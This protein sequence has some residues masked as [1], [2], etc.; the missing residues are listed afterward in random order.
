MP[1]L[2]TVVAPSI[3]VSGLYLFQTRL[4]PENVFECHK[5]YLSTA[6]YFNAID[7]TG[8]QAAM[9]VSKKL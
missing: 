8:A 7:T 5:P 4:P 1:G 6:H 9:Y 3:M 2:F